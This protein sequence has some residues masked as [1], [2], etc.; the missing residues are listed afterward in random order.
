LYSSSA[1]IDSVLSLAATSLASSSFCF[2]NTDLRCA[3]S[4]SA[5]SWAV[6]FIFGLASAAAISGDGDGEPAGGGGRI[7]ADEI[8]VASGSAVFVTPM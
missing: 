2:V 5:S 4:K 6:G 7:G 1:A 3:A 8:N